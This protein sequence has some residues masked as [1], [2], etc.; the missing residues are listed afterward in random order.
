MKRSCFYTAFLLSLS[1]VVVS[2]VLAGTWIDEFDGDELMGMWTFVDVPEE[3][4]EVEVADGQMRMTNPGDFGHLVAD[5]PL[6]LVDAP[7]GDFSISALLS[8]EPEEAS[9]AWIGLFICGDANALAEDWASVS[10]GGGAGENAGII[11]HMQEN[12]FVDGGHPAIPM[13]PLEFKLEKADT[14]YTA[15]YRENAADDWTSLGNWTQDMKTPEKVG[16]GF[17]NNWGGS[18]VTLIADFFQ[19]DGE[20]VESMAVKPADKLASTWARVK[21]SE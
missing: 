1:F 7:E 4:T 19:M 12:S 17:I 11:C 20:D 18:T 6:I 3:T 5:R 13:W 14:T 9:D 16:L 21:V 15:Y 2:P 8:S 10:F